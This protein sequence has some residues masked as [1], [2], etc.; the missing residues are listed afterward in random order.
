MKKASAIP[1]EA[2]DLIVDLGRRVRVARQR[3]RWSIVNLAERVGVDR[4]T[5]NA[6]ELG[7]PGVTVATYI[8]TLWVLGLE[9]TLEGVA[10]P[11]LDSHGKALEMSRLPVRVRKTTKV[12]D[13]NAF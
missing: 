3:R 13:E 4:N 12:A 8:T 7:K 10:S 11:N 9:K 2:R 6:L 1:A 5:L